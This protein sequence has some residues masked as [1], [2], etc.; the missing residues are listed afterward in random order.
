MCRRRER[1]RLLGRPLSLV[2][3]FLRLWRARD[4]GGF[5]C[6]SALSWKVL[7]VR[8]VCLCVCWSAL[9]RKGRVV[10]WGDG[11]RGGIYID[12][13]GGEVSI[14]IGVRL[15]ISALRWEFF[16]MILR[17]ILVMV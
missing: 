13:K 2:G 4:V 16:I 15:L 1:A 14:V 17:L 9:C 11:E 12:W 8:C 5:S 3:G 10:L 6:K 7:F